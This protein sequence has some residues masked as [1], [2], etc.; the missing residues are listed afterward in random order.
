MMLLLLLTTFPGQRFVNLPTG[1]LPETRV[2]QV[3]VSHRFLPAL[4]A[5]GW[6]ND[7]LQ[8]FTGANVRV[9]VDKS[10][11]DNILIGVADA[12][13]SRELGLRA[14]WTPVG[15]LTLYPELNT[16]LY[17]F[18]LDSTWLNF[19][20]S[21]HRTIGEWLALAA[22]PRY[23]TNSKHHF[24]SLGLA[25]KAGLG[26][27]YAAALEAEPVLLGRDPTT[28]QLSLS[29][30][31]EKQVGWHD[32]SITLGTPRGQ[33][34]PALFRSSGEPSAYS[35]VLDPLKG[36]FRVGFNLLRKI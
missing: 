35:D 22:Q 36:R 33:S 32:F 10:L 9:T 16:H 4:A 17:G 20:F 19:G 25:A 14:A 11:G 2:W 21:L 26:D 27:G 30:A 12:I 29:L 15:W 13:S 6:K 24:L 8:T 18:K 34:A 1:V 5:P 7:P 3:A 28:R 23:T 31:I